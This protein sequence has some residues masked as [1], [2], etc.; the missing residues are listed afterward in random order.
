MDGGELND[1]ETF[2][3]LPIL[4]VPLPLLQSASFSHEFGFLFVRFLNDHSRQT[5]FS[6]PE[7][8]HRDLLSE[9]SHDFAGTHWR[10]RME[11]AKLTLRPDPD[12]DPG[13]DLDLDPC[14]HD[15]VRL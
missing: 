4:L 14:H 12:S 13:H 2:P 8:H 9:H 6:H 10:H 11:Q 3:P 1:L 7:S 15:C 5:Y